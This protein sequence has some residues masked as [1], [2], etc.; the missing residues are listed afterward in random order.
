MTQSP[1]IVWSFMKWLKWLEIY[2]E[3]KHVGALKNDI[4]Q[5]NLNSAHVDINS[6]SLRGY[7]VN[8]EQ[9]GTKCIFYTWWWLCWTRRHWILWNQRMLNLSKVPNGK[10]MPQLN[11]KKWPFSS[12]GSFISLESHYLRNCNDNLG[13]RFVCFTSLWKNSII[14]ISN[15]LGQYFTSTTNEH[16]WELCKWRTERH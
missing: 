2:R 12:L 15:N 13:Q 5:E 6:R 7:S 16:T 11:E 1:L 14:F 8:E 9:R 10:E 3:A 4:G